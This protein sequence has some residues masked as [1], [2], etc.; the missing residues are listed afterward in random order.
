MR[1]T[2]R[3][4]IWWVTQ[5]D[6][7]EKKQIRLSTGEIDKIAATEKAL[8]LLAPL[9]TN[10]TA[11]LVESAA[12][13]VRKLRKSADR[14]TAGRIA[15]GDCWEISPH[16][17]TRNGRPL[18][19]DTVTE[20]R[21]CW[22]KIVRFAA[23]RGAVTTAD[24]S[25]RI[26]KDFLASVG[27]R[28]RIV[29]FDLGRA[30][31]TRLGVDQS[32]WTQR[33]VKSPTAVHR[34]PLSMDQVAAVLECVDKLAARKTPTADAAEFATFIRFA[35][36]TGLRLGDAATFPSVNFNRGAGELFR[37]MAK[38]GRHVRFPVH[39]D[40][41]ER[42]AGDDEYLFPSLAHKYLASKTC[43]TIRIR[44]LL[45]RVGIEGEPHQYCAHALRTT[46]ASICASQG[47]P[48]PV[49]QSWL[50]HDCPS[51]TR[52]YARV[53]D[54]KQKRLALAKF[55]TLGKKETPEDG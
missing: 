1:L 8:S 12:M 53:E 14:M 23:D 28:S 55:P 36:Y 18:K 49:I 44:R 7:T 29:C 35:L 13:T 17:Q 43:L 32:P 42:L 34:E 47:V 52:I 40:L 24:L 3:G 10:K 39:P 25:E 21:R 33:P 2:K 6:N 31:F 51:I 54:I 20:Y 46:F 5:W 26:V 11:D 4:N 19:D 38:T 22:E 37:T 9:L 16:T 48:M 15:L 30:M 50:G 27:N 45:K 41:T